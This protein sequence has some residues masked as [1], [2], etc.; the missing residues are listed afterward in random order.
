MDEFKTLTGWI[1]ILLLA[2]SLL[3][4]IAVAAWISYVCITEVFD[5]FKL[6][7][8]LIITVVTGT[9]LSASSLG[10]YFLIQWSDSEYWLWIKLLN[11]TIIIVIATVIALILLGPF[12]VHA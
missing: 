2:A 8:S 1:G 11:T 12:L 10:G 7:L 4:S 9:I 5:D 3:L 6:R